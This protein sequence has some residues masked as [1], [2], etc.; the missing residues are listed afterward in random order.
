MFQLIL[1]MCNTESDLYQK[2]NTA[3]SLYK[4]YVF[5]AVGNGSEPSRIN[6]GFMRDKKCSSAKY[7]DTINTIQY[8]KGTSVTIFI[9]TPCDT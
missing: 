1:W 7:I 2:S 6:Y 3:Y 8:E 4:D 5:S 9:W